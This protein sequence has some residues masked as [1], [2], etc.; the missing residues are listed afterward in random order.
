[1]AEAIL[2][3]GQPMRGVRMTKPRLL[4]LIL[5]S[6]V[7]AP[8][9]PGSALTSHFNPREVVRQIRPSS[10]TPTVA[11]S[12]RLPDDGEFLLDTSIVVGPPP[13]NQASPAVASDGTNYLV[14]WEDLQWGSYD[15]CATRVTPE[16]VVLDPAGIP[17]STA[18]YYEG[19]PALAFD[20][21][22]FLVVWAQSPDS[23]REVCGARVGPDGVVLDSSR[24]VISSSSLSHAYPAVAFDGTNFF[25]VWGQS[26]G[27][28]TYDIYGSRVTPDGAVL[29]PVGIAISTASYDQFAPAAAFDGTNF[30]VVW[31]D[32]RTGA[33]GIHG[34]RVTPDGVVLDPTGIPISTA[35]NGQSWPAVDF[36]GENYLVVWNDYRNGEYYLYGAR[37]TPSGAVLD[38]TGIYISTA[39]EQIRPDLTFDGQNFFAVWADDLTGS[40]NIYGAR[41]APDGAVLDPQPGVCI[42]VATD[43]QDW[44]AIALWCTDFLVVWRDRRSGV[45]DIYGAR[46]T[47]DGVVLDPAGLLT[48]TIVTSQ[49]SPAVASDGTDFQAV[50]EDFRD[51]PCNI[52]GV[53]VTTGGAPDSAVFLVVSDT[54][55]QKSPAI[56]FGTNEYLVAWEQYHSRSQSDIY[57]TRISPGGE[58]LDPYGWPIS[59]GLDYQ[60]SPALVFDGTHFLA[61]WCDWRNSTRPDIYGARVATDGGVLDNH[62]I[63]ISAPLDSQMSP[64]VAFNGDY[65]LVVWRDRRSKSW[66]IY[67]ARVT[68]GGVVLDS[69]G[70]PISTGIGYQF[71]PALASDGNNFLVTWQDSLSGGWNIYGARVT[72]EGIVLD[73]S[74][75]PICT[76]AGNQVS[77]TVTFDGSRYLVVWS[78]ERSDLTYDICGA[79]VSTAG[80]VIDTMSVVVQAGN[81]KTP[82]LTK[83]PVGPTLLVY[84]GWVGT[85]G[86][87]IFNNYRIWAKANPVPGIEEVS[88]P[89]ASSTKAMQT[90][91]GGV[92]FLPGASS[93]KP[94]AAS[95]LDIS[96]RKVME[97]RAG[98]NDVRMLAPGVYFV[99]QQGSRIRGFEDS[100]VDKI[101]I[102]R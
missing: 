41:V 55:D 36:D 75:I 90:V 60:E 96:G 87:E 59:A 3:S 69:T 71:E 54:D 12:R 57:A 6:A 97:L 83:G 2:D 66:D 67:G 78:H 58:V 7:L 1:M 86:G 10:S 101:V 26:H 13:N 14:V 47:P 20:G 38:T 45:E 76:A 77:P 16:G 23:S 29:D 15:V 50:W 84:Q 33:Q 94:K 46:V 99:R 28:Y 25:V 4:R 79:R 52:Y 21:T 39:A 30:L 95:L 64:A 73:P 51:G 98:A 81:Q 8:A 27:P 74:G 35:S 53:R 32:T 11:D 43:D 37:V 17:I 91:I 72:R 100:S 31:R 63:A 93:R 24:I 34:A 68:P 19:A 18:P 82:A 102:T 85:A 62:G 70:I 89:P 80:Q 88:G 56:A 92:L 5:L 48:S 9:S 49:W 44:P 42:S 22:N 65:F 40:N 61:V